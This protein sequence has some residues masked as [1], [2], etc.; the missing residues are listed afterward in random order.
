MLKSKTVIA[1]LADLFSD[2]GVDIDVFKYVNNVV[3]YLGYTVLSRLIINELTEGRL[4][5]TL[6]YM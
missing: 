1:I 6:C 4:T 3:F 2:A 5:K